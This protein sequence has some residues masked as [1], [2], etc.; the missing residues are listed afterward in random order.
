MT[1]IMLVDDEENIVRALTRSLRATGWDVV[2]HTDPHEA[3][4]DLEARTFAA[5]ISDYRMPEISGVQ[6]LEYCRFRQP[7]TVRI[8]LS[9]YADK[10]AIL[11]AVNTAQVFRFLVKPW[12]DKELQMVL[13]DA[14]EK[15][16]MAMKTQRLMKLVN[17]QRS[18]LEE[19]ERRHPGLVSV[20]RDLDDAIL[21]EEEVEE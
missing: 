6:F 7:E 1:R 14:V 10:D 4:R 21:L 18:A 11:D 20:R 5:I 8:I 2:S 3:L 17:A 19:M 15:H 9:A 13:L 16:R 12:S